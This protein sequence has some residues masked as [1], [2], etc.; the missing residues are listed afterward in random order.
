MKKNLLKSLAIGALII[1]FFGVN[2]QEADILKS[3]IN[4][5]D[6]AIRGVQ[7]YS[8]NMSGQESEANVKDLLK[9]QIA[10]VKLYKSNPSK[11][12]DLAYSIRQ[13]CTEFMTANS[14]GSLDYLKLTDKEKSFFPSPKPVDQVNSYLNK[15]ELEKVNSVDAKDP[16]LFDDLNTRIK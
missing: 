12:A 8:I 1:S 13:K 3:F 15:K 9:S 4:K 6:I 16:H 11:S 10:C 7:K 2:A 14:K 5:N